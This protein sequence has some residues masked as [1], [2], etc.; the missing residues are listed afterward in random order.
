[1]LSYSQLQQTK[2]KVGITVVLSCHQ[3]R[4]VQSL[5]RMVVSAHG[6]MSAL[7]LFRLDQWEVRSQA[8]ALSQVSGGYQQVSCEAPHYGSLS[9]GFLSLDQKWHR[10]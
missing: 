2:K 9:F 6:F 7:H 5:L 4:D 3:C 10:S 1:M 8:P